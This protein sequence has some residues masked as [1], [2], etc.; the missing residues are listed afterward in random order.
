MVMKLTGSHVKVLLHRARKSLLRT[1]FRESSNHFNKTT[2]TTHKT[3]S[4]FLL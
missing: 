1:F 4:Q 3:V 2:G